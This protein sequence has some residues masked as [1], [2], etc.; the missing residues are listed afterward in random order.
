MATEQVT[1]CF[2]CLDADQIRELEQKEKNPGQVIECVCKRFKKKIKQ[3]TV[4][5]ATKL[6][7]NVW[8]HEI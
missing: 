5:P 2:T 7:R 4:T 6:Q 3:I 1:S 8:C